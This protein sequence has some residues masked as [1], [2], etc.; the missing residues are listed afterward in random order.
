MLF[1]AKLILSKISCGLFLMH[2][3]NTY[4]NGYDPFSQIEGIGTNKDQ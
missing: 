1:V 4:L 2:V 3:Q